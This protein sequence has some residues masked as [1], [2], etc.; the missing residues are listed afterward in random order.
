LKYKRCEQLYA[1]SLSSEAE[2]GGFIMEGS[3][4]ITFTSGRMR[5]QNRMDESEGQAANFVWWCPEHFPDNI[6]IC[7]DFYPIREPGLCMLFF[8]AQGHAGEDLFASQLMRREGIY[9]QYHSSDIHALHVSYFR[10]KAIQERA[11]H[12]CNLRKSHGF[13][14][15]AQ[16][17]DPIPSAV[18]MAGPYR[19]RV[20]KSGTDVQFG[21]NQLTLFD[22]QDDGQAYG[23]ILGGGKIGF[24]QMA[25]LIAEYGNLIVHRIE[26]LE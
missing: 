26:K 6:E 21:I 13:H 8:A 7:W 18:D 3:A 10:R 17:A 11:F 20:A 25:P 15:V 16:G 14:L 2:V 19:I 1:N 22:W 9:N 5:M 12:V 4:D 23:P 24:R